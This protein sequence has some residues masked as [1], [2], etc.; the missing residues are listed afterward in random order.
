V[1]T[2]DK[3]LGVCICGDVWFSGANNLQEQNKKFVPCK[4]N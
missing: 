4:S 2:L 3:G 1:R